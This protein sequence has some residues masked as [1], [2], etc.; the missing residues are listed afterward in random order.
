MGA[1]GGGGAPPR[2][3]A[4]CLH[5]AESALCALPRRALP[6]L[7]A[8]TMRCRELPLVLLALVLCQAPRGP[9]APVP[10]AGDT[11]LAKMY[12]RGNHWA[13]GECPARASPRR[14]QPASG[15]G[16][17]GAQRVGG[18]GFGGWVRSR[19]S[20]QASSSFAQNSTP[21]FP[22]LSRRGSLAA[23]GW[24]LGPSAL[25]S[26]FP[27]AREPAR[28]SPKHPALRDGD[29]FPC[30]PTRHLLSSRTVLSLNNFGE[31]GPRARP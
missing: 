7:P 14:D 20:T 31:L 23:A 17:P 15:R 19:L 24:P 13:V 1:R 12:P 18:P 16:L 8:G 30:A 27:G 11:V 5:R 2:S 25:S 21:P 3:G 9:A 29:H 4:R 28:G 10:A 6:G 22:V 26:L